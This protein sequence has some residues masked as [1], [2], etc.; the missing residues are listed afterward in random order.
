MA[1]KLDLPLRM[2][3]HPVFHASLL[4]PHHANTISGRIQPSPPAVTVKDA[5][6][7][8]VKEVLDSQV[9]NNRLEYLV[10]WVRYDPHERSWEPASYLDRA[11][12]EI[13]HYHKRY[14]DRPSTQNLRTRPRHRGIA[15]ARP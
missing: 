6:E 10:D 5:L 13:A 4:D 11:P 8:E 2:K 1:F 14:P 12:E 9:R 3:I 15:G 7:Y